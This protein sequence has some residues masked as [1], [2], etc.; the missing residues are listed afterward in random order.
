[1][2]S[3]TYSDLF[4]GTKPRFE[5][6]RV[7]KRAPKSDTPKTPKTPKTPIVSHKEVNGKSPQTKTT[8]SKRAQPDSTQ[9]SKSNA[10]SPKL[11]ADALAK[12][13]IKYDLF[14]LLIYELIL[15]KIFY[16]RIRE[17]RESLRQI[18]DKRKQ[19]KVDE[20]QLAKEKKKE[21]KRVLAETLKVFN[22]V[23]FLSSHWLLKNYVI[24]I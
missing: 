4:T 22:I 6:K 24:F 5:E 12:E 9:K 2:G 18:A 14:I 7:T 16:S 17:E 10:K 23:I 13:F 3:T 21:E 1:M 11:D 20:K 15:N 19:Q 8:P